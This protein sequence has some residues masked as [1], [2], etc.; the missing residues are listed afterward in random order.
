MQ[1]NLNYLANYPLKPLNTLGVEACAEFYCAIH[2]L[3]ELKESIA[4]AHQRELPWLVLGGGSNMVF[5]QNYAGVVC[6][7]KTAGRALQRETP[8]HWLVQAQAG[9]NWHNFVQW[10]VQQGW[11]GLEN[12]AL[13]PGTVGAAPIQNIGAYGLELKDRFDSLEALD[14]TLGEIQKFSKEECHFTYRDSLFKQQPKRYIILNVTFALPKQWQAVT[15]Y[16]DLD[17]KIAALSMASPNAQDILDL[18]VTIRREKLPDPAMIGNVGSFFKNPLIFADQQK[19]L[20]KKFPKLVSYPQLDGRYKLAAAWL[21]EH[22]GWKGKQLG[23]AK[24]H[25]RQALV[26]TNTGQATGAEILQ[27]AWAIQK[28]VEEKFGVRLEPEPVIV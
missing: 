25:D 6:H 12:L 14:T 11:P 4:F 2:T 18:I 17:E 15:G 27:L 22:C 5:T 16:R 10:T 21:I 13:I 9:E 1:P 8:T 26:L 3:A 24:V 20:L 7:L 19:I 23:N 28:D